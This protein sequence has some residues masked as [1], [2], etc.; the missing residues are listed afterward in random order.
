MITKGQRPHPRH[1]HRHRGRLHDAADHSAVSKHV[2]VVIV[3]L[4]GRTA[5]GGAFEDEIILVHRLHFAVA[6]MT[7]SQDQAWRHRTAAGVG[8][9]TGHRFNR[10]TIQV[11][12]CGRLYIYFAGPSP[13]VTM[14]FS[15]A[16]RAAD[17]PFLFLLPPV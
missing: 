7:A 3:P 14:I 16:S 13:R 9:E 11:E 1:A 2:V 8:P 12:N 5:C 6:I 17:L 15:L 10:G 4:A